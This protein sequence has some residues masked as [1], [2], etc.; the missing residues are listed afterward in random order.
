LVRKGNHPRT[1]TSAIGPHAIVLRPP[2]YQVTPSLLVPLLR[3][4]SAA[5]ST[6]L[7]APSFATTLLVIAGGSSIRRVK[8]SWKVSTSSSELTIGG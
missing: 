2:G 1:P 6:R 7:R 3:D 8:S 5:S 4:S